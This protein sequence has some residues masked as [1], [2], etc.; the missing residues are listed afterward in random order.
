MIS[1]KNDVTEKQLQVEAKYRNIV[2][3]YISSEISEDAANEKLEKLVNYAHA[4]KILSDEDMKNY[5]YRRDPKGFTRSHIK[6]ALKMR[7]S[8]KKEKETMAHF[9]KW[10]EKKGKTIRYE[11]LGSDEEGYVL[12]AKVNSRKK[13]PTE[14]DYNVWVNEN[15]LCLEIKNFGKEIWLKLTNLKKYKGRKSFMVIGFNG[16][17]YLFKKKSIEYMLEN[18][19]LPYT[20]VYGKP[21]IIISTDGSN[22]DFSLDKM[23]EENLVQ[24]MQGE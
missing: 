12:L 14:P 8:H 10:I 22:A 17:Y 23:I 16:S 1:T 2:E 4:K 6:F 9:C 11:S 7:S 5:M 18:V 20:E 3:S 13:S 15:F 24:E 21:S 19:S